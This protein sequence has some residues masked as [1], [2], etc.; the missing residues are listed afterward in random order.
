MGVDPTDGRITLYDIVDPDALDSLFRPQYDGTPRAGGRVSFVVDDYRVTID[1]GR[2]V[3]IEPPTNGP[4][5][6]TGHRSTPTRTD[7]R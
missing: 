3:V 5:A 1:G 2:E 7:R 6:S 4:A